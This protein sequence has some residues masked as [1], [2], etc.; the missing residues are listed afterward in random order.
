[1]AEK[2]KIEIEAKFSESGLDKLVQKTQ[3]AEKSIERMKKS[4]ESVGKSSGSSKPFDDMSKSATKAE[5]VLKRVKTTADKIANAKI[6]LSVKDKATAVLERVKAKLKTVAGGKVYNAL[7]SAKDRASSIISKPLSLLKRIG[8]GSWK[9]LIYAKDHAGQIISK[10][11]SGLKNIAGKTWNVAIKAKDGVTGVIR[12]IT[13][14]IFSLK[15]AIAGVMSGMA[16][17][18]FILDPIQFSD[19]MTNSLIGFKTMLGSGSAASSMIDEIKNFART[20]PLD[21]TGVISSV[22]QM[23]NAGIGDLNEFNADGTENSNY[24]MKAMEKIGNAAMATGGGTE[25]MKGVTTALSQMMMTGRVNAQDM[26]QLAI[27][28]IPAWK[29]LAEYFQ[30]SVQ[31]VRKMA[32]D[33][34]LTAEQGIAAI[35]KGFE[36]YDGM[37]SMLSKRT[38]SGIWSNIKDTFQLSIVEKWGNGLQHG[39]IKGLTTLADWLDKISP[40]LDAA[41]ASLE[42]MGEAIGEV[43]SDFITKGTDKI[44]EILDS[45]EFMNADGIGA[46]MKVL[47]KRLFSDAWEASKQWL[48]DKAPD[49]GEFLGK[50]LS[51]GIVGIADF[52]TGALGGDTSGIDN[53]ASRIGESFWDAFCDAFDG[54]KVM[55]AIKRAVGTVFSS[56]AKFL[57]GGE[58]PDL[59]SVL[60]MGLLWKTGILGLGM[61]G[62]GA[63]GKLIKNTA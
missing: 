25:G 57:P 51:K 61:K 49:F 15:T 50:A 30:V 33:G 12:S 14:S 18:N 62:L 39:A 17:K 4:A 10:I 31:E 1:M 41:G 26:M 9:A 29:M 6:N 11:G 37:M 55:T 13:N 19:T 53:A 5:S 8:S 63:G 58:A 24:I 16:I 59:G 27:R 48:E 3:Q 56:A 23:I 35:M 40:K 42:K 22:Q 7:I 44:T 47:F 46:K 20:T 45:P 38:A 32:E 34:E 54:E 2:V 36:R 60:A 52:I 21:T 28:G 43:F